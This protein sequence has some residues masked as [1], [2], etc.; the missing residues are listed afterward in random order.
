[1]DQS[2]DSFFVV[3]VQ[4]LLQIARFLKGERGGGER[5]QR[6]SEKLILC[7]HL[8]L[9]ALQLRIP[10]RAVPLA[11]PLAPRKQAA[12]NPKGSSFPTNTLQD[13]VNY[14][15]SARLLRGNNLGSIFC[16]QQLNNIQFNNNNKTR[17]L[18]S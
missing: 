15:P 16:S 12:L 7:L 11:A 18:V 4:Q 3:I 9:E 14:H 13:R 5:Q 17:L 6:P 1:M 8:G 10:L 2:I